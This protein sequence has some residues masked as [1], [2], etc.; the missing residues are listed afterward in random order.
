ME[1]TG[2]SPSSLLLAKTY[3]KRDV[4]DLLSRY[5]RRLSHISFKRVAAAFG[6]DLPANFEPPLC[7]AC[8]IG[9]QKNI[10]HHEGTRLRATRPC[11]GL[12]IDFCGP[13]P[14]TS[15]YGSRYLL[16][17]KCDFTGY[18]W[19]FYTATQT[20][21]YDI[22]TAL[23]TRLSNQFSKRNV[24]VWIR[25]DNGKVFTQDSVRM[26]CQEK[27][28]RQEFSAP[29]SQW[30]NGSAETT[31]NVILGLSVASLFQSG[32]NRGYW[33]DSVRLAVQCVNRVGELP[34]CFS[35][36]VNAETNI[37]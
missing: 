28:I 16:I 20:E 37:P 21:F 8:V 26:F 27:G 2:D 9:K 29:H 14:I 18:L 17:F 10:P 23:V 11:A 30:Q 36:G 4:S 35:L 13:F 3:T 1:N 31:F 6:I 5:H 24:V 22:L 15:V 34:Q 12:H 7:N 32:L 33:E 25:S 19:D